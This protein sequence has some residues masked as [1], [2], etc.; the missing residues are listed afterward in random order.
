MLTALVGQYLS[1]DRVMDVL[2]GIME[3]GVIEMIM[4]ED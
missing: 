2:Y 4:A 1:I 3:V